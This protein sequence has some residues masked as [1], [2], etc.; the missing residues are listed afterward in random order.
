MKPFTKIL[1]P[2]DF[3]AHSEA[4]LATAAEIAR[5][6]DASLVVLHVFE[7]LSYALPDSFVLLSASEMNRMLGELRTLLEA[8]KRRAEVAGAPR[9]EVLQREGIAASEIVGLARDQA[10]D[11]IVM[12]THGRKGLKHAIMGSVAERV[13][14]SAPCAVLTLKAHKDESE[15]G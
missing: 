5:R 13:V 2:F 14:R 7:P 10:F 6:Y 1:V 3:S 15:A 8:T 9:V 12:G 4:A 11:L